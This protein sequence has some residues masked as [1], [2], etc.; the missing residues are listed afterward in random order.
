MDL[1][2]PPRLEVAVAGGALGL[3]YVFQN[4]LQNAVNGDGVR[5]ASAVSISANADPHAPD[6]VRITIEDNGPGWLSDGRVRAGG[7]GL[8]LN[9]VRSVVAASGGTV[10]LAPGEVGAKV[11]LGFSMWEVARMRGTRR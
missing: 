1:A 4:L 6:W 2:I 8:G 5:G 10:Q 7:H 9:I 3:E 11:E